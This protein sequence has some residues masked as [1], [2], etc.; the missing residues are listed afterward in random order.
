MA[1]KHGLLHGVTVPVK[2]CVWSHVYV[3]R[4]D[5][6]MIVRSPGGLMDCVVVAAGGAASHC[7]AQDGLNELRDRR[8]GSHSVKAEGDAIVSSVCNPLGDGRD[9]NREGAE[10]RK[11][12][13]GLRCDCGS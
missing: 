10:Q 3:R 11:G 9:C 5:E 2:G 4:P 7:V 6:E 13:L 1:V 8:G 12:R